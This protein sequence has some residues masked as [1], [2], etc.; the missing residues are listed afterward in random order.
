MF[1]NPTATCKQ[2]FGVKSWRS[3]S[4]IYIGQS[5]TGHRK[6]NCLRQIS[7]EARAEFLRAVE[8]MEDDFYMDDF[9][10]GANSLQEAIKLQEQVSTLLESGK[11]CLRKW[12]ANDKRI[13]QHIKDWTA[14]WM[15]YF[16]H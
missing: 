15:F 6:C 14:T 8:A 3:D 11:F 2:F 4:D 10:S 13:L 9:L 7:L 1:P 12:R 16:P 5:D